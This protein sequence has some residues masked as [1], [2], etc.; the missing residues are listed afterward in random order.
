MSAQS[1]LPPCGGREKV[2]EREEREAEA[3]APEEEGRPRRGA[4]RMDKLAPWERQQTKTF[5]AWANSFLA[6]HGLAITNIET[7]LEDGIKRAR[8]PRAAC[9]PAAPPAPRRA[10]APPL[11][12]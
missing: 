6:Q 9:V 8:R 10:G 11:G 2:G 5:V 1:G 3:R 7:D 12:D 4:R